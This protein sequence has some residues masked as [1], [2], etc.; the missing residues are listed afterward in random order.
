MNG[1]QKLRAGPHRREANERACGQ[2][3]RI[4]VRPLLI[5]GTRIVPASSQDIATE[6][7]TAS[8]HALR[9]AARSLAG[10]LG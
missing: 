1:R 6:L 4:G 9:I 7:P 10:A 2:E 3:G 8:Q 5:R